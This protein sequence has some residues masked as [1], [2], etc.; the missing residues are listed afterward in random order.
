MN[1]AKQIGIFLALSV[2]AILTARYCV[3]ALQWLMSGY[4]DLI[5]QLQNVFANTSLGN[6]L[7][8]LIALIGV[9]L[10]ISAVIA[11]IYWAFRRQSIP[12]FWLY[13]WGFWLVLTTLV[14]YQ[15]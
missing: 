5:H 4:Q 6:F 8:S 1:H 3:I 14:I 7:S 2:I 9:P 10:I 13:L 12:G 15:G 11:G